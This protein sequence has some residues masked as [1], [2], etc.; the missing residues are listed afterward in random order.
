MKRVKRIA[1]AAAGLFIYCCAAAVAAI[2]RGYC[3]MNAEI[4]VAMRGGILG[5]RYDGRCVRLSG[6]AEFVF[7]GCCEI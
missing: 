4:Q 2:R 5:V 7:D 6:S 1:V 3:R